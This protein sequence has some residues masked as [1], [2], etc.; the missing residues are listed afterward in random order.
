MS[1]ATLPLPSHRRAAPVLLGRSSILSWM[2]WLATHSKDRQ[3]EILE[4]LSPP[5]RATAAWWATSLASPGHSNGSQLLPDDPEAD[6]FLWCTGRGF[7]KTRMGAETTLAMARYPHLCAGRI[8]LIG[9][10]SA[11]CRD[12]M[13]EGESG[14]LACAERYRERVTYKPSRRRLTWKNGVQAFTYSDEAPGR[15]RGPQHGFVW[16]DE[17]QEWENE[18]TFDNAQFGLRLGPFPIFVG[19]FTPKPTP[20]VIALLDDRTNA[21]TG[22]TMQDNRRNLPPTRVAK[23]ER[24]YAGTRVGDQELGGILM[25]DHGGALWSHAMIDIDRIRSRAGVPSLM[26]IVVSVDPTGSDDVKSAET[27]I[28]VAGVDYRDPPHV[29][30]LADYTCPPTAGPGEWGQTVATVY[31]V[32]RADRV[33]GE[34]NYGGK[35]VEANIRAADASIPYKGVWAKQ[36]KRLRAEPVAALYEQHRVHHVGVLRELEDQLTTWI[37]GRP[38]PDRLDALVHAITEL[39]LDDETDDETGDLAAYTGRAS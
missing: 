22:G 20:I 8:G 1:F 19:T 13:V 5:D 3:R 14:I 27:G 6:V 26:R 4:A 29:W 25:L 10:T 16:G 34:K 31:R 33:L 35:L 38:S 9:K 17:I 2:R 30:V 7:G 32:E 12:A 36:G 11:D 18:E 37:P 23:L 15:I 39:V 21:V 24:R 28:I